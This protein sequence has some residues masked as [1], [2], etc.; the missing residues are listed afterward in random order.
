MEALLSRPLSEN[1]ISGAE[2]VNTCIDMAYKHLARKCKTALQPDMVRVEAP[3]AYPSGVSGVS[4]VTTADPYVMQFSGGTFQAPTDGTA[5]WVYEFHATLPTTGR[6]VRYMVREFWTDA[7]TGDRYFS[8]DRPWGHT[9][10][11][12]I[13]KWQLRVPHLW[14]PEDVT[15]VLNGQVFGSNGTILQIKSAESAYGAGEWQNMNQY[16]AGTPSSMRRGKHYQQPAPNIAPIPVDQDGTWGPEPYGDFEYCFTYCVGYRTKNLISQ[17]SMSVPLLESSPSPISAAETSSATKVIQVTLP[18]IDWQVNF[19]AAGALR[20]GHSGIYKRIYR[21]RISVLGGTHTTIEYPKV[22]Q[23]L[24]DVDGATTTY[25]DEGKVV[26]DYSTRLP[27]IH[28]YYAW[29]IWPEPQS[30][31]EYE[32]RVLRRPG[33]LLNDYDAPRV[34]PECMDALT[35]YAASY[36]ARFDKDVPLA[37]LLESKADEYVREFVARYANPVS[38]VRRNPFDAIRTTHTRYGLFEEK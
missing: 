24:A 26:P 11:A 10:P 19:N 31:T 18:E 30:F 22:F 33:S 27:E 3:A 20:A 25:L 16:T 38:V 8:L 17:G 36:V 15:E 29:E 6:V 1:D 9:S 21:R 34:A 2:R 4:V 23:A 14:L 12:T 7:V 35:C 28:G 5:S 37:E 32:L 13:T